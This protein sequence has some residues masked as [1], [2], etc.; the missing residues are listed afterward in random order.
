MSDEESKTEEATEQQKE[1]FRKEGKVAL[2]P[3]VMAAVSFA[4]GALALVG[5]SGTLGDGIFAVARNS[6]EH[7][8]SAAIVLADVPRIT[9]S[10]IGEVGPGLFSVLVPAA[11]VAGVGGLALT[12]FNWSLE[13]L[14]FN[15]DRIDPFAGFQSR[16]LSM[17]AAVGLVKEG[18]IVALVGGSIYSV[19]RNHMPDLPMLP[20]RTAS[21]QV[22]FVADLARDLL[23]HGVFAAVI[24]GVADQLYQMYDLD[25]QMRMSRDEIKREHKESDGDPH[26]KARRRARA[27]Q[28]AMGRQ[29]R[30]VARADVV[31]ANPTHFAVALR[32]RKNENAAPVVIARGVDHVALKIRAEAKKHDILVMENKPLA[33]ALYPACKVGHPI[34]KD[35][36]GPVAQVL[37]VVYK[38]RRHLLTES[39]PAPTKKLRR[40]PPATIPAE[41]SR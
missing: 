20:S 18:L 15:W 13:A 14:E 28:L 5:A 40:P 31:I 39:S 32:Y 3:Q 37:A 6:L 8:G 34:P 25:K 2:S 24:A 4:T 19:M 22:S 16:F 27:R 35:F 9:R 17:A 21:G 29:L 23:W 41:P 26:I 7:T 30:D 12:R 10:A 38:K 1:R 36:Y 11:A 33:R